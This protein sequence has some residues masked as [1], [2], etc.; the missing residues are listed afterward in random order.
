MIDGFKTTGGFY[1]K[2]F[3][4]TGTQVIDDKT[5]I[6]VVETPLHPKTDIPI[7]D[8]ETKAC[9]GD[10][11]KV[12][13]SPYIGNNK[14]SLREKGD[15]IDRTFLDMLITLDGSKNTRDTKLASTLSYAQS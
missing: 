9:S 5:L 15:K 7:K 4:D 6:N 1:V 11:S 10:N 13:R 2:Q 12:V 3:K 8:Y 14:V